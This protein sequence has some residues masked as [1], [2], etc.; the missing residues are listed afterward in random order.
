MIVPFVAGP[1]PLEGGPKS[2]PGS[3]KE[4]ESFSSTLKT[5]YDRS[6]SNRESP[7]TPNP[8]SPDT[9][10]RKALS[11]SPSSSSNELAEESTPVVTTEEI[12]P[13]D[14]GETTDVS[15]GEGET[16]EGME[17]L[18]PIDADELV[19]DDVNVP[20]VPTL[21]LPDTRQWL[22]GMEEGTEDSPPLDTDSEVDLNEET[23]QKEG[24]GK[25]ESIPGAVPFGVVPPAVLNESPL[26][27]PPEILSAGNRTITPVSSK[28]ESVPSL[29][30]DIPKEGRDAEGVNV[31]PEEKLEIAPPQKTQATAA[32]NHETSAPVF[33][34]PGT[35]IKTKTMGTSETAN[36]N[37]SLSGP[38]PEEGLNEFQQ[39]SNPHSRRESPASSGITPILTTSAETPAVDALGPGQTSLEKSVSSSIAPQ[40][41]TGRTGGAI[42]LMG[43]PIPSF[44][45]IEGSKTAAA[46]PPPPPA[47]PEFKPSPIELARQIHVHLESGR[48]VVR[49]DLQPEQLGELHIALEAKGKDVSMQFRVENESARQAVASGLRDLSGTLSTLG[50]S[51]NGLSVS[52]SSGGVGTGRG[53]GGNSGWAPSSSPSNV[54]EDESG[55]SPVEKAPG[56]WRV[57]LVA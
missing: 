24:H 12:S 46:V 2:S 11:T 15:Q 13:E 9:S 40:G 32:S 45:E 29:P 3:V 28:T 34:K 48:S 55:S 50:W 31:L 5:E 10:V 4:G 19:V 33:E 14:T 39:N 16:V 41:V 18:L 8:T 51:V 47:P 54:L 56:G 52:V 26:V 21:V 30:L 7:S 22:E 36:A 57:D 23:D 6:L 53:D 42:P 17:S 43:G 44:P 1:G 27:A 38:A 25:R 49:M 37:T 20:V 35:E